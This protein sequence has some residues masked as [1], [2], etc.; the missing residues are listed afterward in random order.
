[1]QR[2]NLAKMMRGA[3]S[4][5][6]VCRVSENVVITELDSWLG[7]EDEAF[8][9]FVNEAHAKLT[10]YI[11]GDPLRSAQGVGRK[12]DGSL[13]GACAF[14]EGPPGRRPYEELC[15]GDATRR[16]RGRARW[17]SGRTAGV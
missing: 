5:W 6:V 16:S 3:T 17:P 10:G 8:K 7:I 2:T 14:T 13:P 11:R 15:G 4:K 9:E 12:P 1:M